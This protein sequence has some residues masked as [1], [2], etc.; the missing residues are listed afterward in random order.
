MQKVVNRSKYGCLAAILLCSSFLGITGCG[1]RAEQEDDN[2]IIIVD[3]PEE[4]QVYITAAAAYNDVVKTINIRCI[5]RHTEEQEI[6]T[7][8]I[9]KKVDEICVKEKDKVVKGQL[10][11]KLSGSSRQNEIDE[12][13]YRIARNELLL[14]YLD[15]EESDD[16]SYRWWTFHYQSSRSESD[17]EK[18]EQD[19]EDLQEQYR[20][21]R[22]DYEDAINIDRQLLELYRQEMDQCLVYADMEGEVFKVNSYL[23]GTVLTKATTLVRIF[24]AS[25]CVF[26]S[27]QTDYA[28]CFKEGEPVEL[29]VN[30]AGNTH[31]FEVLPLDPKNW[32]ESLLFQMPSEESESI[33]SGAIGTIVVTADTRENVLTVPRGAVYNSQD[34]RHYVYLQGENNIRQVRW[35]ET[36]L[37][38]DEFTEII[39]GLEEGELVLLK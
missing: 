5:Y 8:M 37:E 24:D 19:L 1:E 6:T 14:S 3:H 16:R 17:R 28:Y 26:E 4:E 38:G 35:V 11:A 21:K 33:P 30:A 22:E 9:G 31:I 32:E 10:I 34:G 18:L 29:S 20:Y 15:Q 39:S 12:L 2:T 23:V 7:S 25:Q 36:G 27:N 13:E